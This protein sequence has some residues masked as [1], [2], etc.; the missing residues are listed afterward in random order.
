MQNDITMPELKKS[1]KKLKKKKPPEP[2]AK[3]FAAALPV[4]VLPSSCNV[5][6]CPLL[7]SSF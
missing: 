2:F 5:I 4:I 6:F 3:A 7:P 1:I